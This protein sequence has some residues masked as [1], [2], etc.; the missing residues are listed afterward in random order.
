MKL[1][2]LAIAVLPAILLTAACTDAPVAPV[3]P[4]R[5]TTG[6]LRLNGS[7]TVGISGDTYAREAYATVTA[8]VSPT[9]SYWYDWE[10]QYCFNGYQSDDCDYQWRWWDSGQNVNSVQAWMGRGECWSKFRVTIRS[11]S[12]GSVIATSGEHMVWGAGEWV[13]SSWPAKEC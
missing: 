6:G 1:R 10:Y 3:A 5:T 2:A 11:S 4:G 12:G 8:T 7:T 9:G 13:S